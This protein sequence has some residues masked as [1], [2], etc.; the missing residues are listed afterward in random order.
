LYDTFKTNKNFSAEDSTKA[1]NDAQRYFELALEDNYKAVKTEP[2]N[3]E[4]Y[5][6]LAQTYRDIS[7]TFSNRLD[8]VESLNCYEKIRDLLDSTDEDSLKFYPNECE[9]SFEN[10]YYANYYSIVDL[11]FSLGRYKEVI[12][13]CEGIPT[14]YKPLTLYPLI[15]SLINIGREDQAKKEYNKLKGNPF[16]EKNFEDYKN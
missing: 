8:L 14:E 12:R 16:I 5:R 9:I 15:N 4:A 2:N 11:N 6:H 1:R 3:P 10:Y 13:E 7:E